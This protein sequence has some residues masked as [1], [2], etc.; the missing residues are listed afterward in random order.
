ML[1]TG[2]IVTRK[3]VTRKELNEAW[4]RKHTSQKPYLRSPWL[5]PPHSFF[6]TDIVL[7]WEG[8]F[9][10]GVLRSRS[11]AR[12]KIDPRLL[13]AGMTEGLLVARY[14]PTGTTKSDKMDSPLPPSL[15]KAA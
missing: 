3:Q 12:M 8:N 14:L 6:L 15:T 11:G 10:F 4:F 5:F 1:F 13:P 7:E 2:S 9:L